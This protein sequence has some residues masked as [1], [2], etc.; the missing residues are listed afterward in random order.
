MVQSF[1][2]VCFVHDIHNVLQKWKKIKIYPAL[3]CVC[4]YFGQ[5]LYIDMRIF[6]ICSYLITEG[7]IISLWMLHKFFCTKFPSI[8]SFVVVFPTNNTG[9]QLVHSCKQIRKLLINIRLTLNVSSTH[10]KMWH[11]NKDKTYVINF[12]I[13]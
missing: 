2:C 5:T 8:F 13:F 3:K 10:T 4:I 7:W 1:I 12:F 6:I 11:F 9:I